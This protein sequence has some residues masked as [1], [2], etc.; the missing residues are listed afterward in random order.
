MA[1]EALAGDY[2]TY[3]VAWERCVDD[4][5]SDLATTSTESADIV[6]RAGYGSCFGKVVAYANA[7]IVSMKEIDEP[8]GSPRQVWLDT[9]EELMN[10]FIA[11]V[12]KYRAE[13]AK[14]SPTPTQP[15]TS[16]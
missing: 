1:T 7:Y 11:K 16:E 2:P 14:Q 9:E 6:V 15:Q 10:L 13:A 4:A 3:R 5:I 8:V 12:F